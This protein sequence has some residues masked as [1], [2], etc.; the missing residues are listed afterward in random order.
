MSVLQKPIQY[1]E[2][3]M[4]AVQDT[5]MVAPGTSVPPAMSQQQAQAQA[6][7]Q[8]AVAAAAARDPKAALKAMMDGIPTARDQVCVS[9]RA[10]A[11]CGCAGGVL[12]LDWAEGDEVVTC[13]EGWGK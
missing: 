6:Q 8:A 3:E 7:A 4:R 1:S 5:D 2:E 13:Q 11:V 10:H 9:S 12:L